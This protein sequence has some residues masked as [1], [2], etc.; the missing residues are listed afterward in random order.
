[1]HIDNGPE[2]AESLLETALILRQEMVE[3]MKKYHVEDGP[4]GM[5]GTIHSRHG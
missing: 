1:M 5:P 4:L 3:I 2:E